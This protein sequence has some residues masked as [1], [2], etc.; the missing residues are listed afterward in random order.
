MV[1]DLFI[2]MIFTDKAFRWPSI[3]WQIFWSWIYAPILLWRVRNI[4][5]VHG[6]RSQTIACI[7]AGYA[8]IVILTEIKLTT[9]DSLRRRCGW[10]HYMPGP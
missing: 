1:R 4:R 10:L 3:G 9:P 5:D 8:S 7:V 2:G 6:W